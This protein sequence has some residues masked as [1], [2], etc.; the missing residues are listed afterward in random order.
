MNAKKIFLLVGATA[1]LAHFAACDDGHYINMS[2]PD[3][4]EVACG[5]YTTPDGYVWAVQD[6]R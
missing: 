2:N 5:F 4:T 6:F 3:Y 1:C